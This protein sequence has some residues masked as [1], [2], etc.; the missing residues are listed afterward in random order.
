MFIVFLPIQFLGPIPNG[1]YA[2][3]SI[4]DLFSSE[5]LSGSNF[6]GLGK[7]FSS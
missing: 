6:S 4:D 2:S 5:N 7:Y 3:F 1:K